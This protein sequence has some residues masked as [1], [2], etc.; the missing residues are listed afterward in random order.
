MRIIQLSVCVAVALATTTMRGDE[1]NAP[2][3]THGKQIVETKKCSMCHAIDGK[4]GKTGKPMNGLAEGKTNDFL[5]GAL[6]DPKKTIS[7]NVKMPA[8]KFSD[9][10]VAAIIAYIKSL[11]PPEKPKP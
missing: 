11:N 1:A 7:A 9:D 6:L 10:E 2:A 4:G 5:K 3:I 8:Y